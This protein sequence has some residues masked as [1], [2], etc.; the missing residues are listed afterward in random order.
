MIA[1]TRE[2]VA[3]ALYACDWHAADSWATETSI[4]R[5][6]Y[7]CYADA[8]MRMPLIRAAQA[9]ALETVAR[10]WQNGAWADVLLPARIQLPAPGASDYGWR[11]TEWLEAQ[12]AQME[13]Q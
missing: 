10:R 8:V 9:E 1:P 3:Q 7:E 6:R 5:G 2:Q 12:A 4:T 11:V 13:D